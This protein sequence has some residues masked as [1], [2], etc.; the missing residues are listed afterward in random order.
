MQF[1]IDG[2]LTEQDNHRH[3]SH[4]FTIPQG[5][6]RLDVDFEY[7]P[8]KPG[9]YGNLLTLSL[10]DP[11][12]E[13]GTGHRGQPTQHVTLSS[14]EATPGYL[15]GALPAGTWDIM[16]NANLINAGPPVTYHFDIAVGYDP[17]PEAITY[18]PGKTNPRG[19][20]WYR[21]DLHGH[22][23]HSDGSWD[24]DGLVN[25][26]RQ[27]HLDF[28]TLTDHNTTS[29]LSKMESYSSD[30]L[31][32]MG[33]FELTTFYGHALALG[34]RQ[35]ID[36]RIRPD[37]RT[38]NDMKAEVEALG[39]LFVIAHPAC[40]GDPMCT[41][42][43]WDYDDLMPGTAGLVEIWNEHWTSF[44]DNQNAV[45]LWYQW[46]NEGHRLFAT[47]GTDIHGPA[48]PSL[49]FG[50]DVVY[51]D[52]LSEAAILNAVRQGH[53]YVSSGPKLAFTGRSSSGAAMMGDTL[54]GNS[55]ELFAQWEGCVQGDCVRFI[56]DGKAIEELQAG[57][58]G[59][60]SWTLDG[61]QKHWCLIEVRGDGGSLR[62]LT[63]PIFIT[64]AG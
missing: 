19:P 63:N 45:E 55:V 6:T 4:K 8:K 47:V 56:V 43:H 59:E 58:Q 2:V 33:G 60:R 7:A 46:L 24:V 39:G 54:T 42:C 36:W 30:D 27:H 15:P 22:T 5:V 64:P 41:G 32:T 28:V 48:D 61:A 16:I 53:S 3:I 49:Q 13:R 12:G 26:A 20:G 40:P 52:A 29:A 9:E 62:A 57:T 14:G 25:F 31:L 1:Q 34:I 50:F 44:S 37:E 51:A 21:G 35:L 11:N 23:I 18:S 17:Q 38:I 10:F